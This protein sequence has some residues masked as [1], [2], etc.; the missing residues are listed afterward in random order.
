MIARGFRFK[1]PSTT[2]QRMITRGFRFKL[3]PTAE[4]ET[5][6]RQVAG[7]CRL[8]YNLALE[9]RR[10]W[11]RHQGWPAGRKSARECRT[12]APPIV[13]GIGS[14]DPGKRECRQRWMHDL[15]VLKLEN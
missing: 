11:W 9:Q 14:S 2:E 13:L 10:D 6:F 5:L 15:G 7:V 1:L 8:V 3:A 4:Q 12:G